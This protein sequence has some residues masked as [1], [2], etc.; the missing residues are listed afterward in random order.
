MSISQQDTPLIRGGGA[1]TN[2]KARTRTALL[3]AAGDLFEEGRS[4]SMPEAA[5]RALV[6]VATAYRYFSSAEDLWWEATPAGVFERMVPETL[7]RT[8]AAGPEPQARLEAAVRSSGFAMIDDQAPFRRIAQIA[9]Q[10]WFRRREADET[11]QVPARAGR[12][13]EVIGEVLRPLDGTLP[14]EDV[15]RLAHALGLVFGTEAMIA[16]SDDVGLDGAAA[17]ETLL[18]AGRWLLAGALHELGKNTTA[19]G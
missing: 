14:A 3:K 19:T 16:L 12:H 18:N 8:R 7:E 4:P 2:Q 10:Q 1:R 9:L 17:K 5:D 6:S 13:N 15:E 11:R